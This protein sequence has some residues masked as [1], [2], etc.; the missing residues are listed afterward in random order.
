MQSIEG[1]HLNCLSLDNFL[2]YAIR[3]WLKRVSIFIVFI[4][5]QLAVLYTFGFDSFRLK[6]SLIT[7]SDATKLWSFIFN[8]FQYS[9]NTLKSFHHLIVKDSALIWIFSS[10]ELWH[11]PKSY[12]KS[13]G[14]GVFDNV[15]WIVNKNKVLNLFLSGPQVFLFGNRRPAILYFF[16]EKRKVCLGLIISSL[17]NESPLYLVFYSFFLI[18][19]SHFCYLFLTNNIV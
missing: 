12:P 8:E 19:W 18:R 15:R 3:K 13:F 10:Q 2:A 14:C 4:W 1:R 11:E 17:M 9:L 16:Y 5:F 7:L 6:L